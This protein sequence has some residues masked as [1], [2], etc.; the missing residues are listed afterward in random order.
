MNQ[1]YGRLVSRAAIAA[2]AMASALLLIKIFAWWYTGSV[3]I[4]AAL[5]DSLVDIAASLTNLLVVR[6][7]LQPADEEHTFG[8]GKAES[9]AALAQSMFISGSALFL[10]LTGIQHLVRPEPLQAAG[11]GSSSH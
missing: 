11:V 4:L 10:F 5:V 1:S 3:S 9:L 7:S 2:T 6:Y 8:H